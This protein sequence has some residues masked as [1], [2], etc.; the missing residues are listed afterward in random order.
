[1]FTLEHGR[2]DFALYFMLWIFK[3]VM[4]S[5]TAKPCQLSLDDFNKRQ[6]PTNTV[7]Y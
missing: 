7:M 5:Y 3:V 6:Y 2:M 1:M 4:P